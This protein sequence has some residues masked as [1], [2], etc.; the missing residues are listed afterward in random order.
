MLSSAHP[1]PG[2]SSSEPTRNGRGEA[3]KRRKKSWWRMW[4]QAESSRDCSMA[5]VMF[6]T[7]NCTTD[8]C[9]GAHSL[10]LGN[11]QGKAVSKGGYRE[12][13]GATPFW[14]RRI[15]HLRRQQNL[16][17]KS[18]RKLWQAAF[19]NFPAVNTPTKADFEPPT[20]S[21]NLES[22]RDIHN[23]LC[24]KLEQLPQT[25]NKNLILSRLTPQIK[26]YPQCPRAQISNTLLERAR[27]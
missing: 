11:I 4:S 15:Q 22:A 2:A 17:G 10:P 26:T 21:L 8:W 24:R 7:M 20:R 6:W 5:A 18:L 23:Q 14:R 1:D 9:T 13:R 12:S 16:I 3:G 27:E 19:A 25:W